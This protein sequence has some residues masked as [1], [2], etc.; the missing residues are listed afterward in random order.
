MNNHDYPQPLLTAWQSH[1]LPD[2]QTAPS[3]Q[4]LAQPRQKK[5]GSKRRYLFL[6]F[7]LALLIACSLYVSM[8]GTAG[9]G[10]TFRSFHKMPIQQPT[11]PPKSTPAPG[12]GYHMTIG[13][14]YSLHSTHYVIDN[15]TDYFNTTSPFAFV[16][17][18]PEPFKATH[19]KM[20]LVKSEEA[21]EEVVDFLEDI[22]LADPSTNTLWESFPTA[23]L[24]GSNPYGTYRLEIEDDTS[25]RASA[26]FF[27]E[28]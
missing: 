1:P 26:D 16:V 8:M 5:G 21:D 17:L 12:Y 22:S 23:H 2:G 18:M 15:P 7:L 20:I 3:Q 14:T 11:E 13:H 4:R 24:M 27:Y 19:V 10:N 25:L 28:P 6:F 9:K